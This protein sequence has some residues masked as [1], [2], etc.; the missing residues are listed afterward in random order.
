MILHAVAGC[1]ITA[2]FLNVFLWRLTLKSVN[3]AHR[4]EKKALL[5]HVLVVQHYKIWTFQKLN[6]GAVTAS[7]LYRMNPVPAP[8]MWILNTLMTIL[9]QHQTVGE[10]THS[11]DNLLLVHC[12]SKIV[13]SVVYCLLC[14]V[15]VHCYSWS[16]SVFLWQHLD[17]WWCLSHHPKEVSSTLVICFPQFPS[18]ETMCADAWT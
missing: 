5:K 8:W 18:H 15:A 14:P 4:R 17:V 1:Y 16:W 10:V 3:L 12:T 7:L 9:C 13:F 2:I 6:Q 11:S